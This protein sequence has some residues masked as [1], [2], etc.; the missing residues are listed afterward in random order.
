MTITI[1]LNTNSND[2]VSKTRNSYNIQSLKDVENYEMWLLRIRALLVE[3]DLVSH[4][5]ISNYDIATI[6]ENEQ[7]VLL[8]NEIEKAKSIILLNLTNESLI[9]IQHIENFY[10]IWKALRNLYVS[11]EFNNDFY[12]YKKFFN[13]TLKF[14]ENKM[15]NY[16]NN[17]KRINDQLYAKNIKLFDKIIFVWVFDNLIKEYNGFVT[18]IIQIIKI[19]SDKTLNLIQLFVN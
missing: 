12:L 1:Y 17:F 4:V 13:T 19:N 3:N 7:L 9:Q 5:T 10:N 6:I 11:K 16:I 8:S 14:C 2:N 15:K 18:I